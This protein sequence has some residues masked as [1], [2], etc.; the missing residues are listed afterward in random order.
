MAAQAFNHFAIAL[1]VALV[2]LPILTLATQLNVIDNCWRSNSNWRNNRQRLATCSVGFVGK[3]I[4][5]VGED[6][7]YYTVTS[8]NDDPL[9]PKPGTL[10]YGATL[11]SQKVWITFQR[12]M[13]IKLRKPLLISSFTTIDARGSRIHISG[14]GCLLIYEVINQ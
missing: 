5:N 12:D 7:I 4:D 14:I 13:Y 9:N 8:F 1:S 11:I 6:M 10:R 2:L 3:M